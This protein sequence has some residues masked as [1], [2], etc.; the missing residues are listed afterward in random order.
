[1]A[2]FKKNTDFMQARSDGFVQPCKNKHKLPPHEL[3]QLKKGRRYR[4]HS[5]MQEGHLGGSGSG[6]KVVRI[7][8]A[9]IAVQLLVVAGIYTHNKFFRQAKGKAVDIATNTAQNNSR[10]PANNAQ[11]GSIPPASINQP[12]VSGE[13]AGGSGLTANLQQARANNS[14][15][16]SGATQH[17]PPAVNTAAN[18]SAQPNRNPVSR[19][20]G[21]IPRGG[22]KHLV[23]SGENW[24]SIANTYGI[25]STDLK[26]ANSNVS[27]RSGVQ[28]RI[29]SPED[30][31]AAQNDECANNEA[32]GDSGKTYTVAKG[33][34]VWSIAKKLKV[35]REELLK[36]NGIKDPRK[37]QI[38]QQLKVPEVRKP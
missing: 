10:P 20:E 29:P 6:V 3:R 28:I 26:S 22:I 21:R 14:H 25:D 2:W 32:G 24:Q 15:P 34:N 37:L 5:T 19:I 17:N 11:A 33:D 1:M 18:T 36:L 38:G 8:V 30:K 12:N 4:H 7:L 9:V 31:L 16:A 23:T 35:D 13:P 27:L